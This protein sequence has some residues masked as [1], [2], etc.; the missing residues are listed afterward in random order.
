MKRI[1]LIAIVA[2]MTACR[3]QKPRAGDLLFIGIPAEFNAETGSMDE[4]I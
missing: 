2:L 3:A 4:A 1:C